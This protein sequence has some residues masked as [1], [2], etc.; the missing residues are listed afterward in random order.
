MIQ[1]RFT[2]GTDIYISIIDVKEDLNK[3]YPDSFDQTRLEN[4]Y[5]MYIYM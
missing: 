5:I 3:H 4:I 1:Y 2:V